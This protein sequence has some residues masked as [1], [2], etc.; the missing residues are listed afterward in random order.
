MYNWNRKVS[1]EIG[2][3]MGVVSEKTTILLNYWWIASTE[4][5][6]DSGEVILAKISVIYF[7][8]GTGY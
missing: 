7:K 4:I 6:C 8:C 1:S 3:W 5:I 2:N